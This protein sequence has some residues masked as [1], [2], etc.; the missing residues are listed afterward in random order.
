MKPQDID[1]AWAFCAQII[2]TQIYHLPDRQYI[3]ATE[4]VASLG[5]TINEKL[6]S[7]AGRAIYSTR[8]VEISG[9]I[10]RQTPVL[11]QLIDTILHE[12]AHHLAWQVD[13]DSGH[14]PKWVEWAELIGCSAERTHSM[15]RARKRT[16]TQEAA[17]LASGLSL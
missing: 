2:S 11:S 16:A 1:L 13:G 12:I 5:Y 15:P 9:P 8:I 6:T 3:V 4:V 17:F 7:T 10:F 14:G